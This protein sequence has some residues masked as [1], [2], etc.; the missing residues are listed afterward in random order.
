MES[1]E[2]HIGTFKAIFQELSNN[3]VNSD[4]IKGIVDFGS[5]LL[6]L[7]NG[8][9]KFADACGGLPTVLMA[10]ASVLAITKAEW[11]AHLASVV[12]NFVVTKFVSIVKGV[13]SVFKSL[14]VILSSA[15]T[16]WKQYAAGTASASAAMQASIPVIG[17]VLSALTLLVA[18]VS[19]YNNSVD[20]SREATHEAAK[21]A[22]SLSDEIGGLAVTYAALS[23]SV[24]DNST[25]KESLLDTQNE[26]I[27]S[28]GLEQY[29]IDGLI[30]KYG[31]L[32]TAILD[33]SLHTLQTAEID[34]SADIN[35]SADELL[36][37]AGTLS[38]VST[39]LATGTANTD[40][41]V[42]AYYKEIQDAAAAYEALLSNGYLAKGDFWGGETFAKY[43][44]YGD[45]TGV[46]NVGLR[47]DWDLKSIDGV[48][49]AYTDLQEMLM[50][51]N[52][53]AGSNNYIYE[54]LY[55]QYQKL[56]DVVSNYND[57]V[58]AYNSNLVQQAV[59]TALIG[60][61][62]PTTTDEFNNFKQ[63]VVD[64]A[65]ASGKFVGS[66]DEIEAAI[67]GV[68][69]NDVSFAGFYE[70]SID[71]MSNVGDA[72]DDTTKKLG[73][74][75]DAL[76]NLKKSYSLVET[77]QEEM[78]DGGISVDTINT[79]KSLCDEEENYLDYLYEENGVI[80]LNVD[81]WK[82][83]S[84]AI[85]QGEIATLETT[86][87]N[88]E[89]ENTRLK[90]R[91]EEINTRKQQIENER[92]SLEANAKST[93][94]QFVNGNISSEEATDAVYIYLQGIDALNN[95]LG[96]LLDEERENSDVIEANTAAI[97]ENQS[98]LSIY[99]AAYNTY[100]S[101]VGNATA[102][103]N[104]F[105]EATS[106]IYSA[107]DGLSQLAKI[108]EDVANGGDFDW[109]SIL[110]NDTFAKTFGGLGD[111]YLSFIETIANSPNDLN[112]CQD[113]FDALTAAYVAQSGVLDGVTEDTRAVSVA[114][115]ESMGIANAAEVV[116]AK[117]AYD[118]ELLRLQTEGV[119]D[120]TYD[121]IIALYNECEAGSLT[122]QILA[123]L[124][125]QKLLANENGIQTA[126]DIEQLEGLANAANATI[127]TLN[128]LAKA[129]AA[130]ANY[131][132]YMD[133]YQNAIADESEGLGFVG[134]QISSYWKALADEAFAEA[135]SYLSQPL[136][137]S[138]VDFSRYKVNYSGNSGSSSGGG[139]NSSSE[140]W[141]ERQY[142]DHQHWLAM[143]MESTEDYLDWL[144]E[145]YQQAYSEGIIDIDEYY[146]YQEE[147]YKGYQDL[148]KDYLGDIDHEVSLLEKGVGNSDE[149][150][151]LVSKAMA[152]IEKELVKARAAGLDENGDYIQYLEQQWA[153]YAEK[154]S[155]L[156]A[157]A[158]SE[159]QSSIDDLVDYRIKML[160]QEIQDEKD[161][162]DE[163]LDN[164]QNF[165]DKQREMLQDQ[166]DEEKYLEEQSEKRKS[167]ADIQAELAMLANDNSAWAQ[168]R[169]LE[170]QEELAEA[171]KELNS[172]E[173]DHAL[174][175][176]LDAL[177]EQQAAQEAQIQAEMDA[178]DE[179][180]NDPHALFNQAL[181]DIKN[182]TEELYKEFIEYNRKYGTGNDQDIIDMWEGAYIADNEYQDTHDGEHL[183]DIAIGNYTGYVEPENP[184]PPQPEPEPDTPA[185]TAPK[186]E[187][188]STAPSLA[189][190]ST[191]TVKSS[192]T[193]FSAKS[194]N[195][196]M[197]SF[198]PGG[199]YTVYQLDGEEVLI[200][201][202]GV[203]TGW[204]NKSD[205]VGYASGTENATAGLHSL[206]ELGSEYL[207][208]SSD[209][210]KYRVL[211][212]GDKVLNAKATDFLYDFA[213]SGGEILEKI[214]KSVFGTS[215]LGHIQPVVN[216]N[217][218]RMG[219]IVV[220]G[221]ATQQ[222]VSEIRRAQR[223]NLSEMLKSLNKLNK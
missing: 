180:L 8:I 160:K 97:D 112:A 42:S 45:V 100:I 57:S 191:V 108:Y 199:T 174:D 164:L 141:F 53:T 197:A 127:A 156:R 159:A 148:F 213:N 131:E 2:G 28:L 223:E 30:S 15:T 40:G 84:E 27:K 185:E 88:L 19:L 118:K 194:G 92:D 137:F 176:T 207:F 139:S 201:L 96:V 198:V 73:D 175:V 23:S 167:V 182:N 171:E 170:L 169:R 222:T 125:A 75:A 186:T 69:R 130:M 4:L 7:V 61:E 211:N 178:L 134:P 67:D 221:S 126:S 9:I 13:I 86:I 136:E 47:F 114:M 109:G 94:E 145:A 119:T 179:K 37:A 35:T 91:N 206:D 95:E 74:L 187:P 44:T 81:L 122:S 26:L 150:I 184:T 214:I 120:K 38:G 103:T 49:E 138:P 168:K 50:L 220:Q 6:N 128:N 158:E 204:I 105:T 83:R 147:V 21:E 121:E 99:S 203:Y 129:K 111:A 215:L 36:D 51:V 78:A 218:I 172:F 22:A 173:R 25:A 110:N 124:A 10:V 154:V 216:H 102:A 68:L 200:G 161:A 59:I 219:D 64:A 60:E 76:S 85:L 189:K 151:A 17:L 116:D 190:G 39:T 146:K 5:T 143:D 153:D 14:P 41:N 58:S 157:D 34:L 65:T 208:T 210:N 149:V 181:E 1:I 12:A 163:K 72:T 80:K 140:T 192:A 18:G 205:I 20:D 90:S 115:L 33:A 188:E 89:D 196:R 162:L 63:G 32:S 87:A 193:H 104:A 212:S 48:F 16:A 62:V 46:Y 177:D 71:G 202:N 135:Q 165:Y 123:Q 31:D 79:L 66:A 142:K 132:S 209:G 101:S 24:N 56:D 11:I 144:N 117:L 113:A 54:A 133:S 70:N 106:K 155:D 43:A 77:A 3:L 217:E 183:D 166:Y 29:Q 55:A 152:E 82:K 52:N 98:K 195:A 93:E 107:N